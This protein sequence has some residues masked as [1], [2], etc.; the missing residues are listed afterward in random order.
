MNAR[1]KK[2][3]AVF[4]LLCCLLPAQAL[5]KEV[6]I[7]NHTTKKITVAISY[8]HTPSKTWVCQGWWSV[9]GMKNSKIN[10]TT[11]NNLIYFVGTSGSSRWGGKKGVDGATSLPVVSGKFLYK[12]KTEK[13]R[14]DNPRNEVFKVRKAG[15]D[16]KFSIVFKD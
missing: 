15:S 16:G 7:Q 13:P 12:V 8:Y 6:V 9:D 5:A 11:D 4:V 1:G 14:G 2:W 10:L 3:L